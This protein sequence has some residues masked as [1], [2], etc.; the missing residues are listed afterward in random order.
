MIAFFGSQALLVL[1]FFGMEW[2]LDNVEFDLSIG[3]DD[4]SWDTVRY[5]LKTIFCLIP[6]VIYTLCYVVLRKRQVKW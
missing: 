3:P 5:T 2:L 1:F 4:I 6:V